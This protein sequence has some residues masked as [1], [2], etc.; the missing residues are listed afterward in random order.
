MSTLE[1]FEE[2][3]KPYT[4]QSEKQRQAKELYD[5]LMYEVNKNF[6]DFQWKTSGYRDDE[7]GNVKEYLFDLNERERFVYYDRRYNVWGLGWR[8]IEDGVGLFGFAF[9]IKAKHPVTEFLQIYFNGLKEYL[10]VTHLE[11]R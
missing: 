7:H 2:Y 10:N 3:S 8:L 9:D 4:Y 11:I 6:P 5:E 1:T